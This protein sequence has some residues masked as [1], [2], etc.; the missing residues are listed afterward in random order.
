MA[1]YIKRF[2]WKSPFGSRQIWADINYGR[3]NR[4]TGRRMENLILHRDKAGATKVAF[5]LVSADTLIAFFGVDWNSDHY[6]YLS[7]TV[8]IIF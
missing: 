5:F 8:C 2:K 4:L 6:A 3:T 7:V 1:I